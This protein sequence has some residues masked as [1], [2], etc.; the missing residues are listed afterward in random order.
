MFCSG[1]PYNHAI[2]KFSV[3][4]KIQQSFLL[5]PFQSNGAP[6]LFRGTLY[7]TFCIGACSKLFM[8]QISMLSVQLYAQG[9]HKVVICAVLH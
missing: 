1:F 2:A 7:P 8:N 5:F 6:F 4:A 3:D 9:R